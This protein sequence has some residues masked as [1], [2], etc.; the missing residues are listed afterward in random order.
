MHYRLDGTSAYK[1]PKGYFWLRVHELKSGRQAKRLFGEILNKNAMRHN[2][3]SESKNTNENNVSDKQWT[4]QE[5]NDTKD[6]KVSGG[7]M[8]TQ[9]N[10]IRHQKRVKLSTRYGHVWVLAEDSFRRP[11]DSLASSIIG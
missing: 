9:A 6:N 3:N 7:Q 4:K 1:N 10:K 5:S 2:R 11:F 8:T